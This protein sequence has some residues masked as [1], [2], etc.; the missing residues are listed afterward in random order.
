MVMDQR[1]TGLR[2]REGREMLRDGL[3]FPKLKDILKTLG[4][5]G[6]YLSEGVRLAHE[7]HSI[8]H[9]NEFVSRDHVESNH[10]IRHDRRLIEI[11]LVR[12]RS[13]LQLVVDHDTPIYNELMLSDS[14]PSAIDDFIQKANH[15]LDVLCQHDDIMEKISHHGYSE[16]QLMRFKNHIYRLEKECSDANL[17]NDSMRENRRVLDLKISQLVELGKKL[18]ISSR[19]ILASCF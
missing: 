6:S 13:L 7:I 9:E 8:N 11:E 16:D 3:P 12:L 18:G 14:I 4:F 10:M 5:N 19:Q 2:I 17:M 1:I 15:F